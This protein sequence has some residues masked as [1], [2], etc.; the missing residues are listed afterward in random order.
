M[1]DTK[2]SGFAALT[3][4]ASGDLLVIVDVSDTS[5]AASGTNKKITYADLVTWTE[6]EVDFGTVPVTSASFTVT[7]AKVS[8]TSRVA[9]VQSGNVATGRVGNDAEWDSVSYA[10]LPGS[11]SFTL[12]AFASG[13]I[14]GKRKFLYQVAA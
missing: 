12:T 2:I 11:G 6:A 1:A 10:A 3:T 5:M 7:D 14:A 4:P 8:A 9:V 13:A